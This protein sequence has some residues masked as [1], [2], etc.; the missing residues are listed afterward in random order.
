MILFSRQPVGDYGQQ[1]IATAVHRVA[2]LTASELA[3]ESEDVASELMHHYRIDPLQLMR[4]ARYSPHG[5]ED[6]SITIPAGPSNNRRVA[7]KRLAQHFPFQGDPELFQ[8]RSNPYQRGG[9]PPVGEIHGH[10]LVVT[11]EGP[12]SYDPAQV[13]A[14]FESTVDSIVRAIDRL[15]DNVEDINGQMHREIETAL[16][17]RRQQ[18]EKDRSTED[19]LAIPVGRRPDPSEIRGCPASC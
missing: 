18:I 6:A 9:I 2:R 8:C 15:R 12:N 14:F 7:G 17:Q 1:V 11:W 4:E 19:L 13:N 5:F 16:S 10:E 3:H